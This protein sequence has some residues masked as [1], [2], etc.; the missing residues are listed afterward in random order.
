MSE[1]KLIEFDDYSRRVNLYY[2]EKRKHEVQ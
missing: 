1:K 2:I